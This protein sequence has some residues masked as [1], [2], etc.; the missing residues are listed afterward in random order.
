METQNFFK[1]KQIKM[2]IPFIVV[3][4]IIYLA[5]TGYHFGQWLQQILN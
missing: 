2:L 1:S 3:L 5:K 4:G